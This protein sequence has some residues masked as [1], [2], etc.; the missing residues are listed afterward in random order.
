MTAP[1]VTRSYVSDLTSTLSRMLMLRQTTKLDHI[2]AHLSPVLDEAK[3][4]LIELTQKV[5]ANADAFEVLEKEHA[6]VL[7]ANKRLASRLFKLEREAELAKDATA[8]GLTPEVPPIPTTDGCN[9]NDVNDTPRI[10]VLDGGDLPEG[11][12]DALAEVKELLKKL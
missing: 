1:T 5:N 8:P 2:T 3:N 11:L 7:E 4:V 12:A 6:G 9:A 10:I